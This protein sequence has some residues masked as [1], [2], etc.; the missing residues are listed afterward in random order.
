MIDDNDEDKY[1]IEKLN[2]IYAESESCDKDVFVEMRSN[3]LLCSG[4]HYQK[5]SQ[6]ISR[7]LDKYKVD[8]SKRLR[9]VK[10]HTA[11]GISDIKDI[12][13]SATPSVVPYPANENEA[14]HAKV[15]ELSKT[16]W[17]HGKKVNHFDDLIEQCRNSFVTLGEVCSKVYFDPIAGG[18]SGSYNQ[19]VDED[20]AP[21]F[22]D[23]EGNPTT[24]KGL[25]DPNTLELIQQYELMP[26]E[27]SPVFKGK[28]CI[29]KFEPYNLLRAKNSTNVKTSK[30]LIYRK[31]VD[32]EDAKALIKNAKL[33]AEEADEKMKWIEESGKTTYKIFDGMNGSFQDS[34]GQIMFR[35]F[36][37]RQSPEFPKGQYF[38]TVEKGI[39]F[40]GEIPFGEHGDEAFPIKWEPYEIYEGSARGFSPIKRIRPCQAEINRCASSL[41]ETQLLHGRTKVVLQKGDKFSR[42]ATQPGMDVYHTTGSAA[43]V[44]DGK[45]GDQYLGYL[46]FN[47][48]ELY[49]LLKIPENSSATS[50]AFDPKAELFKKQSQKQRF[51][52]PSQR[53]ARFLKSNCETHL[54]LSQKYADQIGIEDIFGST[55]AVDANEFKQ[56]DVLSRKITLMEVTDD[57]ESMLAKT[58]ELDTILQYAGKDLDPDTLSILLSQYPA[59]NKTQAFK[60]INLDLNNVMSDI[61]ALDRGEQRP[62]NKYDKHELYVKRL[63]SRMK[64]KDFPFLSDQIKTMYQQKIT[65]HEEFIKFMAQE[66]QRAAAGFIPSGGALVKTD[67]YVN[68][69]PNNPHKAQRA[70]FPTEAL[71]WLKKKLEDQGSTLEMI[72]GLDG[73]SSDV[74]RMLNQGGPMEQM[75]P[76]GMPLPQ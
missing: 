64:E 16:V 2:K 14:S 8:K 54:F 36:Y 48:K 69:D 29:E 41:S 13:A 72:Q 34:Q 58:M 31:M 9:L 17:E 65:D 4:F 61:L 74:A 60:H 5:V 44:I 1:S 11:K 45:S 59:I 39:L 57:L 18:F 43:Q 38:I 53:L 22:L 33:G 40:Q 49:D 21:L 37:F 27:D 75:P 35:E 52:E 30:H 7:Q 46:E 20:G 28:I 56:L 24:E 6:G 47:I 26:D 42:G 25:Y 70:M 55:Q 3:T 71:A 15:A 73:A 63:S 23:L 66:Q 32:L 67:Y 68:P 76:M 10:N 62:A 12:L 19:A 50:Q 51:T